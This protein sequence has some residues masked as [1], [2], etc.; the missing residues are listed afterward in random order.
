MNTNSWKGTKKLDRRRELVRERK[1][2]R[3]RGHQLHTRDA[4]VRV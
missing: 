2:E 1:R 4:H 3:M